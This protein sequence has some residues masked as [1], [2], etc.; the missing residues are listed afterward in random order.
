[1]MFEAIIVQ[2]DLTHK[3]LW[4][5]TAASSHLSRGGADGEGKVSWIKNCKN[6]YLRGGHG[7]KL[8]TA[9]SYSIPFEFSPA[10]SLQLRS[11]LSG[12]SS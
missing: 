1:M 2:C 10:T 11:A 6:G 4:K 7:N 9:H 12:E 5:H 8:L 3:G